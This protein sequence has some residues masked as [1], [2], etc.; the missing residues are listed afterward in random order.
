MNK[1]KERTQTHI[2]K[3]N[4]VSTRFFCRVKLLWFPHLQSPRREVF[5]LMRLNMKC[6][7]VYMY[8]I[9]ERIDNLSKQRAAYTLIACFFLRETPPHIQKSLQKY[10]VIIL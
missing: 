8:N 4:I 7:N 2:F 10:N 1:K 6:V 9:T 3:T 5:V